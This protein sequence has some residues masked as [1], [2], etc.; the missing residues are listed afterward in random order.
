MLK[1]RHLR[2]HRLSRLRRWSRT[3]KLCRTPINYCFIDCP[4]IIDFNII[5]ILDYLLVCWSFYLLRRLW[6]SCIIGDIPL[7]SDSNQPLSLFDRFFS[8]LFI[9]VNKF[10]LF[11]ILI[12]FKRSVP[13]LILDFPFFLLSW[14]FDLIHENLE[15]EYF[16]GLEVDVL[17]VDCAGAGLVNPTRAGVE[18]RRV[19]ASWPIVL[20]RN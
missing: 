10:L 12:G 11:I 2:T 16:I 8:Q 18:S 5:L 14:V 1:R 3:S 6:R 9:L 20:L 7:T 19:L 13:V 15:R 4:D 17:N